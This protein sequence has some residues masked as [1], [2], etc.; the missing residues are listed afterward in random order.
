MK[1]IGISLTAPDAP[2]IMRR[3]RRRAG[4]Q[5]RIVDPKKKE[6]I[7]SL[8][9]RNARF[10]TMPPMPRLEELERLLWERS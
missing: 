7:Q 9:I 8:D 5:G 3:I 6:S 10:S 2:A 4:K 1:L